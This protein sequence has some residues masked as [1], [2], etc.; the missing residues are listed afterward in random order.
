MVTE[1]SRRYDF[2]ESVVREWKQ[3]AKNWGH[4]SDSEV[5]DIAETLSVQRL[6]L[7]SKAM[8]R[9]RKSEREE[10]RKE[11]VS[12]AHEYTLKEFASVCVERANR[13]RTTTAKGD[14]LE[15]LPGKMQTESAPLEPASSGGGV[16][17]DTPCEQE[18]P[19]VDSPRG[20]QRRSAVV[21]LARGLARRLRQKGPSTPQSG[22]GSSGLVREWGVSSRP[23]C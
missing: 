12:I 20:V 19:Q 14:L 5:L 7:I 13:R 17:P 3:A 9:I 8:N 10:L 18:P 15:P 6:V 16:E 23:F 1:W 11:L 21:Q 2:R 4:Y 22:R